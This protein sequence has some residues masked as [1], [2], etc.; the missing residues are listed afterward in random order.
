MQKING[1]LETRDEISAEDFALVPNNQDLFVTIKTHR[2]P[3][4]HRFAWALA[5]KV[6]D[7]CEWLEDKDDAMTWLKMKA[8]HVKVIIDKRTGEVVLK[9]KS[10]AFASLPQDQ[11]SRLMNRFIWIVVNDVIPEMDESTLRNEI[12]EMVGG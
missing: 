9:P 8:K 6:S 10:I 4:Q 3:K 1:K 5:K 11:F 2:S 7:S 12:L